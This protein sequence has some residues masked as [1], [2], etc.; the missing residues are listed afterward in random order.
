MRRHLGASSLI[1]AASV[2]A[3]PALAQ[4]VP[5]PVV[6]P[7]PSPSRNIAPTGRVMPPANPGALK[8]SVAEEMSKAQKAADTRNKAWDSKM[9]KTMGSICSG[10]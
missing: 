7:S 1:L 6:P 10:C 2:F 3:L 9:R 8:P 5:G 4:T